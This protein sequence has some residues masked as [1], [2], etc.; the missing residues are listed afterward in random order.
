WIAAIQRSL[1]ER[2]GRL[3]ITRPQ[4]GGH[5]TVSTRSSQ[6]SRQ[7]VHLYF[8]VQDSDVQS[9]GGDSALPAHRRQSPTVGSDGY[10]VPHSTTSGRGRSEGSRDGQRTST[11][12]V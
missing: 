12:G 4:T 10:L 3:S 9:V 8:E 1:D 2:A 6:A 5:D 11:S 7:S